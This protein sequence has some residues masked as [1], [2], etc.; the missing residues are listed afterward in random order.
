M[1]RPWR[2]RLRPASRRPMTCEE[3]GEWLQHYLDGEID[4][5]RSGRLVAHLEECKRCGLELDVYERIKHSLETRHAAVPAEAI[6]RL[7]EFG[8][9]LAHGE[10]PAPH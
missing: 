10:D 9:R 4:E 1:K 5:R 2:D 3:V 8:A 6:A 7:R